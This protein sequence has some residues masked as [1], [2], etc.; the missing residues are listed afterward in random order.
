[1]ADL[2]RLLSICLGFACLATGVGAEAAPAASSKTAPAVVPLFGAQ[3]TPLPVGAAPEVNGY[4]DRRAA[5]TAALEQA[6][7]TPARADL[8]LDLAALS[9]GHALAPEAL[10]FLEGLPQA[11]ADGAELLDPKRAAR[12]DRIAL[13][14][15]GLD[16]GTDPAPLPARLQ[17]APGASAWA[18]QPVWRALAHAR[19]GDAKAA[20]GD[21]P[22]VGAALDAMPQA[23]VA[24]LLP[25]LLE[26]AIE[27]DLWDTAHG[28]AQRFDAHPEL[29]G[30]S[31]YRFLLG[32]AAQAGGNPVMAFDSYA[33]AAGGTDAWAQ[34]ARLALVDLGRA[35]GTLAPDDAAALLRQSWRIWRGDALEVATLERLAEVEFGRGEI[36][37]AIAA[38]TEVLRRH[39]QSDAAQTSGD[40]LDQMIADLY[41]QG[42]SGA[43]PIAAFVA[44]HR[45]LSPELTFR[46]GFAAQAEKLAE[47]LLEIGATDAAAR[48]Y[49]AIR[50]QVAVMSD[51]GLEAASPAR[52]DALRLAQAEA[53]LRG[54]QTAAAA[55]AL[56]TAPASA[57]ELRDRV[58]LLR[59]RL[60]SAEGD[61]AGV[62][63]TRMEV[64]SEGYLRLRAAALFD[65]GDWSAAR[66]AYAGLW[67]DLGPGLGS[68]DTLRLLLAAHRAGDAV[69]V[70]E[71]LER[72]PELS[73]SPELAAIAHS[74]A[75][76][77][78]LSL[79]IG[80]KSAT[81][82]MQNADAALRRLETAAGDG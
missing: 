45:R 37:A 17:I 36:E 75:P 76:V 78:P 77:A 35:T 29:R 28:L 27:A 9:V 8:L 6:G 62:I 26:A 24:A 81:D 58:A 39:P 51:L 3:A 14:V 59:A 33:M 79:P 20:A 10:S 53:L 42:A 50:D 4:L 47:R 31:A 52:L 21:L 48:E 56:G 55:E 12:R 49:G 65:R 40:R 5:L 72:L 80:Q 70:A 11:G 22:Q 2:P 15:W 41:A 23:L 19:E 68:G 46:P 32:R 64:P 38:L 73:R 13:A 43:L 44:A 61:G 74:L 25:E 16:G 67:R 30:G 1:M 82:R 69:L 18:E 66:D 57:P 34:R 60:S 71:L 63:A 7:D 54:G